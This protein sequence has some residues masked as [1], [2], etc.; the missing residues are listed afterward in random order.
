MLTAEECRERAAQSLREA[1]AVADP[2]A[3]TTLHWL[4]KEWTSLAEQVG[5]NAPFR[6]PPTPPVKR[7][8]D[9]FRRNTSPN[10]AD[11]AD[12][13]RERLRLTDPEDPS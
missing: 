13:L 7:P 1:E 11:A 2:N 10:V 8:A 3:R 4:A 9:L 6:P 5:R 12:S